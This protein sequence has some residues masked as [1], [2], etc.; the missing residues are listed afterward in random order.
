MASD[1]RGSAAPRVAGL[2]YVAV[3]LLGVAQASLVSSRMPALDDAEAVVAVLVDQSLRFRIGALSDILLYALVLVLAVALYR[4]VRDVHR[5]LALGGLVLRS[6]EGVL[7]LAVTVVG[8][9]GPLFLLSDSVDADPTSIVPLLAVRESGLD[10]ILILVGVG[11]ALFLYL[12]FVARLVPRALA[13]WG[14]LTYVLVFFLGV[15]RL[16]VPGF[17]NSV[18]GVLFAQGALFELIFGLWLVA[19]APEIGSRAAGTG[20]S[21]MP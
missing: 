7:G 5:P 21:V 10:A 6:A 16:L 20:P 4:V 18:S 14:I 9:V 15:L 1:R 8:G 12:F 11:G 19:K 3:I 13:V 2:C 17:P